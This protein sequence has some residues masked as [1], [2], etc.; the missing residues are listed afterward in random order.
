MND[1]IIENLKRIKQ[2]Y[3]PEGFI[4]LG[5]FGSYA[6]NEESTESDID[7]LYELTPA[8]F[9][10]YPGLKFIE[11]Y[12][13]VKKDLEETFSTSV[14]LADKNSLSDIGRKYIL[15]EVQYVA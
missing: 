7:I 3:E 12:N 4:I 6:R 11:L 13:Q 10:K 9:Q 14:D 8:A 15:S 5:I 2:K 1:H